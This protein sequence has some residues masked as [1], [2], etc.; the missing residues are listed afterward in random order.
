MREYRERERD[1]EKAREPLSFFFLLFFFS[2]F[3][4]CQLLKTKISVPFIFACSGEEKERIAGERETEKE[5]ER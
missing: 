1:G 4:S 2:S 3:L 5:R